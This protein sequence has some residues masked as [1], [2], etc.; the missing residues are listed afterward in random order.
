[1]EAKTRYKTR[2][3][4]IL[5]DYLKSSPGTHFTAKDVCAHFTA[6]NV[7]IGQ[8]TIY[9]QLETLVNEG[10][11]N[12]YVIDKKSPACFEYAGAE[13]EHQSGDCFHC[14]CEKC[15]KLIHLRCEELTGMKE[16]LLT[17]QQFAIDPLR[18]VLYGV[19]DE[20]RS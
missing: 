10:V 3:K 14:K 9:R 12:K 1:M 17:D 6:Q 11:I 8:S 13:K 19:C 20:C 15:G 4:E 7:K 16:H 18:T 5:I 2:Q